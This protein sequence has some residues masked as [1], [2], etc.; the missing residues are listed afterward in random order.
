[1]SAY[2]AKIDSG[3]T[4]KFGDVVG[5][6]L[7]RSDSLMIWADMLSPEDKVSRR[8]ALYP[9]QH[10]AAKVVR[11][12]IVLGIVLFLDAQAIAMRAA[13]NIARLRTRQRALY[14]CH[15]DYRSY[16]QTLEVNEPCYFR[17]CHL[18]EIPGLRI[19]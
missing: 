2:A 5:H 1:M 11:L 12:I 10:A 15:S 3:R 14:H 19:M 6:V 13:C 17:N 9:R 4:I 18:A 16:A 8:M 7:R